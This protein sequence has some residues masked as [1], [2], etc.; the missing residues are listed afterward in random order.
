[1]DFEQMMAQAKS[2]QEKIAA[3]QEALAN[4]H[5]KGIADNGM[6][7]VDMTGKY[8]L[9]SVK[10]DESAMSVGAQKLSEMVTAAYTDAKNK[11]DLLIDKTMSAITNGVSEQ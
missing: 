4:M 5:V 7:I 9:V 3:A 10:I 2:L 11:A 8:D 6:V 1:M